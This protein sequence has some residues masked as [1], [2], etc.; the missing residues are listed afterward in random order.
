MN[1]ICWK[2]RGTAFKGFA[3]LVKDMIREYST[4]F[5]ALL[6]THSSGN[7]A[8]RVA[9]RIGLDIMFIKDARGQARRIWLLWDSNHWNIQILRAT[10]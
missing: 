6:E 1:L 2:C 5:V 4:S 9:K 7:Q 3:S 10:N 8:K